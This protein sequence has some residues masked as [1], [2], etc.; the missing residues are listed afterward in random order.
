LIE[1]SLYRKRLRAL[2]LRIALGLA[3][4]GCL[5]GYWSFVMSGTLTP[6][7]WWGN[8][9]QDVGTEMLGAAVTILLVELVIYQKRDEVSRV[10]RERMRRRDHFT[11]QLKK[12]ISLTKRQKILDRLHQQNLLENSWLYEL[13]LRQ[14]DLANA[15]FNGAD[16]FETDL[17]NANLTNADFSE[18]ILQRTCFKESNL[19]GAIFVGAD[20]TEANFKG[21]DLY[22]ARLTDVELNQT[23]FDEKTRLPDGTYWQPDLDLE[24]VTQSG[25]SS[26]GK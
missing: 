6:L 23:L 26:Q 8:W 24:V 12:T 15:N 25:D 13:N 17:S 20:L 9:L 11:D 2:G 14:T 10:D 3:V 7:R 4:I 19:Q 18:A 22:E 16:L 1:Q 5:S 21:A